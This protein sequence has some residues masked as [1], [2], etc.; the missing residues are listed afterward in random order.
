MNCLKLLKKH[1]DK[2][3]SNPVGFIT[4]RSTGL[5]FMP[6]A[7]SRSADSKESVI[8][9]ECYPI[10]RDYKSAWF[11]VIL[12]ALFTQFLFASSISCSEV[13]IRNAKGH[14]HLLHCEKHERM[15]RHFF[16]APPAE[17]IS[18]H[19]PFFFFLSFDETTKSI[20]NKVQVL[21]RINGRPVIL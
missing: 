11:S 5:S 20:W 16:T 8:H 4:V 17:T 19:L 3:P 21:W 10:T 7:L 2:I 9:F 13:N 18:L 15:P 1:K 14:C 6:Q 12:S